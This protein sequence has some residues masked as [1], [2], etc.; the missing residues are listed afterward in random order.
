MTKILKEVWKQK[1]LHL[2]AL[3]GV[4]YY[5]IF[6]Y[7]PM[8]GVIIAFQDYNIGKGVLHSEWV[9]L[10]HFINFVNN[11]FFWRLIRNT[12]LINVYQIIF[13]FPIPIVFALFL[14]EIR[15]Q[16]YK[17]F[18]QTVSY[19]PH[20]ISLPAIIGML[21]MYLSPTDGIVNKILS[22]F[23]IEPIYFLAQPEWFRTIY[24][25]SDIW[26]HTGWSAIIYI[27]ALSQVNPE[28]YESAIIDGAN[29]IQ[30]MKYISIPS[31]LPTITIM[32]LLKVGHIMSLGAE[33]VLLLQS[34]LNY[35]TSDVISTY[36]YRRGLIYGE[37]SY[38]TAIGIF[39]S[40][41]NLVILLIANKISQKVSETSLW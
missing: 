12:I 27:A 14:N 9:G 16:L 26:Q 41:I 22:K 17:K 8:Y 11:P 31:I 34:P 35:E 15:Q 5:I 7:I 28:L 6:H 21:A 13:V 3:P 30:L 19:L 10:K 1:Y 33:K 23:G 2:L 20:F 18:V 24:I 29:R 38:T 39:N 36:V 32:F 40:V 4:I 37:Y 25:V